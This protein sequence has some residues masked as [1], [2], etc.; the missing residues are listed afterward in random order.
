VIRPTRLA[1]TVLISVVMIA[2]S[3][4]AT[5]AGPVHL[6]TKTKVDA[7]TR[8]T[9]FGH[10]VTF[11]ATIQGLGP[12][13]PPPAGSVTFEEASPGGVLGVVTLSAAGTAALAV[14]TLLAGTHTITATFHAS[15]GHQ[16]SS[17]SVKVRVDAAPTGTTVSA[18]SATTQVGDPVTFTATISTDSS[19]IVP[20]GSVKFTIDG[21]QPQAVPVDPT[22]SATFST[23]SLSIGSH[24]ISASFAS[25]SPNFEPSASETLAHVVIRRDDIVVGTDQGSLVIVLDAK[26]RAE[27][28]RFQAFPGVTGEISVAAGDVNGDGVD[29]IVVGAP[30]NGHV[31]VCDGLTTAQTHRV[32]AYPGFNGGVYVAA[33]DVDGDGSAEII[34]G[35][36][37]LAPH[38]KVFKGSSLLES[39]LAFA[40]AS[41]GVRVGSVDRNGDGRA[42]ILAA[43]AASIPNV[44]I[45]DGPSGALLDNFFALDP[46]SE[47]GLFIGGSR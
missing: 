44:R 18:S 25:S 12:S 41:I 5:L 47:V 20:T 16:D 43:P 4:R 24:T 17:D 28:L 7:S 30:I 23:D 33:G 32:F 2:A 36:A 40:G 15:D 6:K 31:K 45:F 9:T 19:A 34:T 8:R 29:D 1:L 38:V 26:T 13:G 3:E 37:S 21:N 46:V 35:A 27:R 11:Q 39:Y 42:D 14:P 10:T 22:G